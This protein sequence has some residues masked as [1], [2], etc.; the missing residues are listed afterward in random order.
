MGGRMIS[1]SWDHQWYTD[2]KLHHEYCTAHN[3]SWIKH[4]HV[5]AMNICFQWITH[6]TRQP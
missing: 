1:S 3:G 5:V 2:R 6:R 4:A